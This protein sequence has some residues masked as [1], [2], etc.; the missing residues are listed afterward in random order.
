LKRGRVRERRGETRA[1]EAAWP[2]GPDGNS[3]ARQVA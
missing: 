1:R 3:L 2:T